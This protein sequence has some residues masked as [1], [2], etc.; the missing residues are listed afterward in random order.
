MT[1]LLEKAVNVVRRMPDEIQD[2][3]A[4]AMLELARIGTPATVDPDHLHD[5]LAG[6]AEIAKGDVAS[7]AEVEEAF[8]RFNP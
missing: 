7:D 6:L 8:R 3:I 2:D 4:N 5:I 1:D